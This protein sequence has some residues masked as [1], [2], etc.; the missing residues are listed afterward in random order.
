PLIIGA[1][2]LTVVCVILIVIVIILG[3][4]PE[5]QVVSQPTP[6][7]HK[8]PP[9]RPAP[10][11]AAGATPTAAAAATRRTQP[12]PETRPLLVNYEPAAVNLEVGVPGKVTIKVDRQGYQGP[13]SLRWSGPKEVRVSPAGPLTLQPGE[14]DPVLTL[15]VLAEPS[16]DDL[17]L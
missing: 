7:E 5:H 15:R 11:P 12:R 3:T 2:A 1:I 16:A 14:P 4:Q 10:K 13:I 6:T 9:P 17:A 8:P